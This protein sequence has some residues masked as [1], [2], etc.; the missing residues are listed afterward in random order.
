MA[1]RSC[2]TPFGSIPGQEVTTIE[3]LDHPLQTAWVDAQAPQCGYCQSGQI[4]QAASLLKQN[5][6]PTDEEIVA[7]M[8][9]N[10]CRCMACKRTKA[11]I[12]LVADRTIAQQ[13]E[14]QQ[15]EEQQV[16]GQQS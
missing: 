8:D 14:G 6:K 11:A 10:L 16:E 9:G 12:K 3:G 5:P 2:I 15:V 4:M 1:I 7:A 13:V